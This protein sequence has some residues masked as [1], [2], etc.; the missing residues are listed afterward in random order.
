MIESRTTRRFWRL[1]ASLPDDVQLEAKQAYRHF[2]SD[3]SHPSLYFKKLE[4]MD[5][6]YSARIGLNHRALAVK[7]GNRVVWSWIGNHAEYDSLV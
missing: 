7:N 6:V 5:D 1:F 2:R 4:G 3:P